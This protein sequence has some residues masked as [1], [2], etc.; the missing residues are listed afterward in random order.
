ML[1]FQLLRHNWSD[2]W[3]FV[4]YYRAKDIPSFL[5]AWGE[6]VSRGIQERHPSYF[7]WFGAHCSDHKDGFYTVQTYTQLPSP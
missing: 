5:D 1:Y 7:E 3:S 4:L 6:L 2:E